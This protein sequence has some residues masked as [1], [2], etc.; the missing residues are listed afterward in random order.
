VRF[1]EEFGE[2]FQFPFER[3]TL[4]NDWLINQIVFKLYGL[5]EAET[6]IVEGRS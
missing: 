6:K 2:G 1:G 4:K 3:K 5:S